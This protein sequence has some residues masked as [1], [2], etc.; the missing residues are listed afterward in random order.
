MCVPEPDALTTSLATPVLPNARRSTCTP[1]R[2]HSS[3]IQRAAPASPYPN[4]VR[5]QKTCSRVGIAGPNRSVLLVAARQVNLCRFFRAQRWSTYCCVGVGPCSTSIRCYTVRVQEQRHPRERTRW[6]RCV[7]LV[8]LAVLLLPFIIVHILHWGEMEFQPAQFLTEYSKF[9]GT[10]LGI[11]VSFG[12]I[13]LYWTTKEQARR[14]ARLLAGLRTHLGQL[15]EHVAQLAST[16]SGAVK[17]SAELQST[18]AHLRFL[19]RHISAAV[20]REYSFGPRPSMW[21][22][23]IAASSG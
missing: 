22:T 7:L 2:C 5:T 17:T 1:E 15:A 10:L 14:R 11:G 4:A 8:T 16:A 18:D 19:H 12:L 9:V 23:A 21:C 20:C 13:Q 6:S 3:A